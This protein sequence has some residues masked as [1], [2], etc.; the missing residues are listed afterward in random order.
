MYKN[1]LC[2]LSVASMALFGQNAYAKELSLDEAL[3]YAIE[4]NEDIDIAELKITQSDFIVRE[5]ES[6]LYPSITAT[7]QYLL[8]QTYTHPYK[9]PSNGDTVFN[10]GIGVEVNQ[11]L[12][13]FG[14]IENAIETA[15]LAQ[16]LMYTQKD[17]AMNALR[18]A[19]RNAYFAA[20]MYEEN[21]KIAQQSYR[22][23]LNTKSR[24][25]SSASVRMSQS[26]LIKVD[27]DIAS[28]K[29]TVDSAKLSLEKSYRLLEVLCVLDEPITKLS[30]QFDDL[31]IIDF[32]LEAAIAQLPNSPTIKMLEQQVGYSMKLAE[33]RR[34]TTNPTIGLRA[35]YTFGETSEHMHLPESHISGEGILGVFISI[36][37]YDGGKAEA[38]AMQEEYNARITRKELMQTTR[39]LENSLKDAYETY[40]TNLEVLKMDDQAIRL[41]NRSYEQSLDRF[42]NGQASAVELNDVESGLTLLK[43]KRIVTIHGIYASLAQIEQIV[44]DL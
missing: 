22:N 42:L 16:K 26:D 44:G 18:Y 12:F 17:I 14:M 5:A 24:L 21:Y 28:R 3:G 7:G 34:D 41:A 38:Q 33:V 13:A 6:S 30:S 10:A 36:P 37:L 40:T 9:M 15:E 1:I 23:A 11:L 32:T 29:P 27:A 4:R 8:N 2:I 31:P 19:I 43:Q 25:E 20:L 35:S 39:E